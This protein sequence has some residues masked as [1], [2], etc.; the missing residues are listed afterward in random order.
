M[1]KSC[2]DIIIKKKSSDRLIRTEKREKSRPWPNKRTQL[3]APWRLAFYGVLF[4]DLSPKKP[5]SENE[6]PPVARLV[7]AGKLDFGKIKKLKHTG[8]EG[9]VEK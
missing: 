4:D 3:R 7:Q 6:R 8:G 1:K 5:K 9:R 2:A